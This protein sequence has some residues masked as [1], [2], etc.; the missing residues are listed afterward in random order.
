MDALHLTATLNLTTA[1]NTWVAICIFFYS[2]GT[3]FYL[4]MWNRLQ[5]IVM[6]VWHQRE[7]RQA[8]LAQER[9]TWI[10][11]EY[12][13]FLSLLVHVLIYFVFIFCIYF[14]GNCG[15]TCDHVLLFLVELCYPYIDC[16]CCSVLC[17][18]YNYIPILCIYTHPGNSSLS[19]LVLCGGSDLLTSHCFRSCN[20]ALIL[21]GGG[22]PADTEHSARSRVSCEPWIYIYFILCK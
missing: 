22:V 19:F 8:Q 12:V 5:T 16:P 11:V 13:F 4:Y 20:C 7:T 14:L 10:G 18:P 9:H 17:Y 6:N 15:E 21:E 3:W 1:L 2:C